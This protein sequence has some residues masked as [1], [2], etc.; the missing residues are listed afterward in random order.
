MFWTNGTDDLEM[1]NNKHE[2]FHKLK[3]ELVY[4]VKLKCT[5][6]DVCE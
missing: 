5:F 4:V 3:A 2:V 1:M 6:S